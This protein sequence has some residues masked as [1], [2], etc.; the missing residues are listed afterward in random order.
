MANP[1]VVPVLYNTDYNQ[2]QL[3]RPVLHYAT[4]TAALPVSPFTP[5]SQPNIPGVAGQKC[6]TTDSKEEWYHDGIVWQAL[7]LS[8]GGV[9]GITAG[10]HIN[11]SA[12]TGNV[13]VHH[14][15]VAETIAEDGA[16]SYT[17]IAGTNVI[18]DLKLDVN[19]AGHVEDVKTI[20][21]TT[22]LDNYLYWK[23]E[24]DWSETASPYDITRRRF[25]ALRSP[26]DV[27]LNITKQ[28]N[29]GTKN[30]A[31]A[32][33]D[34]VEIHVE[35][36]TS[37]AGNTSSWTPGSEIV[38]GLSINP[39]GHVTQTWSASLADMGVSTKSFKTISIDQDAIPAGTA[40]IVAD[41]H[42]DTLTVVASPATGKSAYGIELKTDSSND[43]LHIAHAATSGLP[44]GQKG[45]VGEFFEKITVDDYGH[46]I[47]FVTKQAV[48]SDTHLG[49]TDLTQSDPTR[50]YRMRDNEQNSLQFQIDRTGYRPML[51]FDTRTGQESLYVGDGVLSPD[52]VIYGDLIVHGTTT[53]INSEIVTIDDNIIILNDNYSGS[54]PTENGGIEINRDAATGGNAKLLWIESSQYWSIVSSKLHIGDI[55]HA[56]S[57]KNILV[58]DGNV[59]KY[60][61]PA[62]V[63]GDIG[64][65][66]MSE[67]EIV[68]HASNS[69]PGSA[70]VQQ[71]H[72]V[73]FTQGANVRIT[74]SFG[75]PGQPELRFEVPSA[76]TGSEGVVRLAE[77]ADVRGASAGVLNRALTVGSLKCI[78][79]I[80]N[81][82]GDDTTS[83]FDCV[84]GW[85][86]YNVMVEVI[87]NTGNNDRVTIING[88][89]RP[90]TNTVRIHFG[91]PPV[92]GENYTVMLWCMSYATVL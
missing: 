39:Q 92:S 45:V 73:I 55:P 42:E 20:D 23:L 64:A 87:E 31:S 41:T 11:V 34:D 40:D 54:N 38:W 43:K 89:S 58:D 57:A 48:L 90:N 91:R 25:V 9:T 59:V 4:K 46:I 86:T 8:A 30:D 16:G 82:N 65:G 3:I 18:Q 22:I 61:T 51:H 1:L 12:S 53:T 7:G 75:T 28:I 62:E 63:R 68:S 69:G 78:S 27:S 49:N 47:G 33:H 83:Y 71:G 79:A 26:N 76:T 56:T 13:T 72:Q 24:G 17:G 60:R 66:T 52:M 44:S 88:V 74:A 14:Q 36:T 81:I 29:T 67:W 2:F 50:W 15:T 77:C 6:Y 32:L 70:T 21:L 19:N 80:K 84:H 5:N 37:F 35:H 85:G 10:L